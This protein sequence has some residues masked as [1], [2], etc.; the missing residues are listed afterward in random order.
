MSITYTGDGN[1]FA[2]LG[3]C[4]RIISDA[5][6]DTEAYFDEATSGDYNHLLGVSE[7]WTEVDFSAYYQ[8]SL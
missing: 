2:I 8:G 3:Y 6:G 5:G 1:A 4:R 7:R